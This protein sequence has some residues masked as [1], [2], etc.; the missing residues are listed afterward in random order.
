MK[1]RRIE[2]IALMRFRGATT[3]TEVQF[4]AQKPLSFIFGENGTGKSSIVDAIDFVCN[5]S[6]G[7]LEDRRL[8]SK[9]KEHLPAIGHT[10]KDLH[11]ELTVSGSRFAA[12]Y[13]GARIQVTNE[14]QLPE[15]HVLRRSR[16]LNL[17][18]APASE[19]YKQLQ[20]FIDVEGV[21]RSEQ[22]L[23]DALNE[24]KR[25]FDEKTNALTAAEAEL[26]RL[27]EAEGA[28]GDS[29][30][31]WAEEKAA[32]SPARATAAVKQLQT[33]IERLDEAVRSRTAHQQDVAAALQKQ[34]ALLA[35]R[36]EVAAAEGL[37][38]SE[39]IELLNLLSDAK[40]Y[41]A[42]PSDV[43]SCPVCEQPVVTGELRRKIDER[44][45][46]MT[47]LGQL[48]DRLT[49]AAREQQ[50]AADVSE[51]SNA[52]LSQA[53][54]AL[55]EASR[56]T[57]LASLKKLSAEATALEPEMLLEKVA[58]ARDK[59][60]A[61]RDELQKDVNQFNSIRVLYGQVRECNREVRE[62]MTLRQGLERVLEIAH[63]K[64]VAF[65]QAVLDGVRDECNRLYALI[66][67]DE[68]LALD[69]LYL[70][71]KQKA[72]LEQRCQ[73]EDRN[74]VIPQAYFSESHLDTLGFCL[75][76][77][78]A[79]LS[80]GGDS[81]IVLDDVFTSVDNAHFTRILELLVSESE[82]FSQLIVTTHNRQWRDRY[83]SQQIPHKVSHFIELQSWSRAYGI[84]SA[85]TKPD[86][87]ALRDALHTAPFDR[88]AAASKAGVL[89]ENLFEALAAIYQ[90]RLPYK[91]DR[92]Y[93]LGEYC[94]GTSS[95][96]K[97]MKIRRSSLASAAGLEE[98]EAKSLFEAI[99]RQTWIRNQVGAHFNLDG[100]GIADADVKRFGQSVLDLA[101]TIICRVCGELP[102]KRV[103]SYWRCGCGQTLMTPLTV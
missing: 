9:A 97:E 34:T 13:S 38:A 95:L 22:A 92:R 101:E 51:K 62:A 3:T 24:A 25:T 88:Q 10:V 69:R 41:L 100:A 63:A 71:E 64:R 72:S 82:N 11:V 89:A 21:E 66:H 2:K 20:S 37:S 53:I 33:I 27:W 93:Q 94:S 68:P 48:R 36:S 29:T 16:L 15:A 44:L 1:P 26:E 39:S 43:S 67:P 46:R 14:T 83:A 61:E 75:W 65:T 7:S 90:C 54:A 40:T 56:Q 45:N 50:R 18:E 84:R 19:K 6:A 73:F 32:I 49:V 58:G 28:P 23:R 87:D 99:A 74:D 30:I 81:V 60:M 77:S 8:T 80:S 78:V 57:D 102:Q 85:K 47:A 55:A 31:G 59:L 42:A 4:D 17:I 91:R 79:K 35:I 12:G 86:V 76:L 52:A 70:N 98:V 5:R 96:A 103:D